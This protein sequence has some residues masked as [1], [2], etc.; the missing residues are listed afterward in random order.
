MS[1]DDSAALHYFTGKTVLHQ[2]MHY[3]PSVEVVTLLI[4]RLMERTP[5]IVPEYTL[6]MS[7]QT[8][9]HVAAAQGCDVAVIERLMKGPVSIFP[10]VT[11][12]CYGRLPLHWACSNPNGLSDDKF[13]RLTRW[14]GPRS[15]YSEKNMVKVIYTL[16]KVFPEALFVK[17]LSGK[18]PT[19]LAIENKAGEDIL[20]VLVGDCNF[21][22]QSKGIGR[23][24]KGSKDTKETSVIKFPREVSESFA[25][26]DGDLSS[27]GTGG[28]S[29]ML[30][31]NSIEEI[32]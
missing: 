18:T 13:G 29:R 7:Q 9:L 12:D 11:R 17:D 16:V 21:Q 27:I 5:Q 30:S 2:L 20:R 1:T 3:H 28:I 8:P 10:A 31:L 15:K 32:K 14:M 26:P 25:E 24:A 19:E 22:N 6:D 4:N 23:L